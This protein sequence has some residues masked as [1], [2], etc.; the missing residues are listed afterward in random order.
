MAKIDFSIRLTKLEGDTLKDENGGELTLG[1][2]AKQALL[3][4]EEKQTGQEKYDNYV[5]ATK[6]ADGGEVTLKQFHQTLRAQN[7]R[8]QLFP[9]T[10]DRGL[11]RVAHT[12]GTVDLGY[13][14]K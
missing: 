8:P 6:V 1:G 14:R 5:L 4:S 12:I 3:V 11:M 2:A 9:E 10:I 7:I 13:A